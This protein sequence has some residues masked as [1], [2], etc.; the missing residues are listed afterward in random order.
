MISNWRM[1][2]LLYDFQSRI[3]TEMLYDLVYLL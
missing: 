2:S 3:A 1:Q